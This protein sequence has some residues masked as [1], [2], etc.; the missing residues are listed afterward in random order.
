MEHIKARD[1]YDKFKRRKKQDCGLANSQVVGTTTA[2]RGISILAQ[3][4]HIMYMYTVYILVR[5][6]CKNTHYYVAYLYCIKSAYRTVSCT[7]ACNYMYT[8]LLQYM[9]ITLT[10]LRKV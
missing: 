6:T 8:L 4:T 9:Y 2:T 1:I 3:Y 5:S 7:L 10:S